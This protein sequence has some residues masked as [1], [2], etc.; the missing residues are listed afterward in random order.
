MRLVFFGQGRP[1]A[2]EHPAAVRHMLG[3]PA[4]A[5]QEQS[6]M[7]VPV[8]VEFRSGGLGVV[9]YV[10]LIYPR[11]DDDVPLV[12][13]AVKVGPGD[14]SELRQSAVVELLRQRGM[15]PDDVRVTR[16]EIE[17]RG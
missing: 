3:L 13:K 12:V 6:S 11:P 9:P 8:E 5:L 1:L 14:H 15:E 17:F 4:P 16:S 7:E 10:T 2:G